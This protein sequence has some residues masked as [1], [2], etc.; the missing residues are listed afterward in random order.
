MDKIISV[1]NLNHFYGKKKVLD[2]LNFNLKKGRIFGLLGKNGAGKT[3]A[4]NIM[5]GFLEPF[6]GKCEIFHEPSYRISPFTRQK[7][8]LLHETHLQYNFMTIPQIEKFY[9]SFYP[10]W[11]SD[12]FKTL[13]E[14]LSLGQ[15]HKISKMSRGQ[16]SQT[17]LALI[18]AQKPELMILDDYSLGLDPGYRRLF[19]EYL[20]DYAQSS[21][22]TILM[23]SHI[24]QDLEKI[25]DDI[26]ILDKGKTI[27][28]SSLSDFMGNFRKIQISLNNKISVNDL[29][30]LFKSY[31]MNKNNLYIYTFD[32]CEKISSQLRKLGVEDFKMDI[33]QM[34]LED[35]FIGITGKY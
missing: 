25:V 12:I 15:N 22:V 2:N 9:S 1:E 35:A 26:L 31:E 27:I 28:N 33:L 13:T 24:V 34:N 29:N 21:D 23:T 19:L 11:D 8:G 17:A 16:K 6:S 18:L 4:I 3:T 20:I 14:K 10:Q 30:H 5:M 7:I 32:D